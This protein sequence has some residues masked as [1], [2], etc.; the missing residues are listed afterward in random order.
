MYY[1]STLSDEEKK[2]QQETWLKEAKEYMEELKRKG[3]I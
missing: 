2:R 3:E 1:L